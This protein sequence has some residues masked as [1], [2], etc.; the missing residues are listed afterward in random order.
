MVVQVT[1]SG[2]RVVGLDVEIAPAS[3]PEGVSDLGAV[4]AAAAAEYLLDL[5]TRAEG[6]PGREASLPAG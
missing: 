5:A 1:R 2:G 4:P 3:T 6:R